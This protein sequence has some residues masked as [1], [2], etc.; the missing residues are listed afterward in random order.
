MLF[1]GK[2]GDLLLLKNIQNAIY[3]CVQ[4]KLVQLFKISADFTIFQT[5]IKIE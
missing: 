4:S 1:L 3:F 2:S 5:G